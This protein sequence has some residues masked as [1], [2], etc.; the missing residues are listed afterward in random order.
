MF[1]F[2]VL[3]IGCG[4]PSA[5]QDERAIVKAQSKYTNTPT[6]ELQLR[7][8]QLIDQIAVISSKKDPAIPGGIA[9]MAFL[10]NRGRIDDLFREKNAVERELLRRWQAGDK[11]AKL[12]SLQ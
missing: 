5:S 11:A 1:C 2:T 8:E 4:T 7:R 10:D 9:T 3:A 6:L 12:P